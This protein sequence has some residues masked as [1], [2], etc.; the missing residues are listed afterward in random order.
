ML[1][2]GEE[3]EVKLAHWDKYCTSLGNGHGSVLRWEWKLQIRFWNWN[4]CLLI[5]SAGLLHNSST[6]VQCIPQMPAEV[7]PYQSLQLFWC[8]AQRPPCPPC[9]G[10]VC[11]AF[12]IAGCGKD[13]LAALPPTAPQ[14]HLWA[15][16]W[17]MKDISPA[18][19]LAVTQEACHH[20]PTT[21]RP[22]YK[23]RAPE[24]GMML[25]FSLK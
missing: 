8:V 7:V 9:T 10:L 11:A 3:P 20:T 23:Q 22:L 25:Q 12:E 13:L 14:H 16:Q 21:S 4:L 19:L 6:C 24:G 17:N 5:K 2:T 18:A 1:L 15:L